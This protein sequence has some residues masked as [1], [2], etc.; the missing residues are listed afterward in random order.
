MDSVY[1]KAAYVGGSWQTTASI[2]LDDLKAKLL[3]LAQ[4]REG[5]QVEVGYDDKGPLV[6]YATEWE[7][8]NT[9]GYPTKINFYYRKKGETTKQYFS[10][11][12][13]RRVHMYSG[14]NPTG[15]RSHCF[16]VTK[17]DVATG[18]ITMSVKGNGHGVGMS[19]CGAAGYA[20]E[21][22][23]SYTK[24]LSHYYSIDKDAG[25]QL[26]APLWTSAAPDSG[27]SAAPDAP[28]ES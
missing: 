14:S 25:Y 24:I 15:L 3:A 9:A 28:T 13:L 17:Y 7:K 26:V 16:T 11:Y 6:L 19:Q 23:W 12:D 27:P 2:T 20:N 4:Q 10:G 22:G 8:G 1:D 18:L 5:S 21:A